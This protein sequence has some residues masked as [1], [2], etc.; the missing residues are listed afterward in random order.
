MSIV[1]SVIA[2][3]ITLVDVAGQKQQVVD[4]T[5]TATELKKMVSDLHESNLEYKKS[6][7]NLIT[8][9][10]KN[11]LEEVKENLPQDQKQ[12]V[13]Q[14]IL[15]IENNMRNINSNKITN[16]QN[17]NIFIPIKKDIPVEHI[18]KIHREL[19]DKNIDV[20][21][22][23][24]TYRNNESGLEVNFSIKDTKDINKLNKYIYD[25]QMIRN[26]IEKYEPNS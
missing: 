20:K 18:N 23:I 9:D 15:N 16:Y 12:L 4:I 14:R 17:F 6:M 19:I 1:L 2:I 26:L 10:L 7:E 11:L 24:H 5:N 25:E 13:E 8:S 21:S 22:I 3:V